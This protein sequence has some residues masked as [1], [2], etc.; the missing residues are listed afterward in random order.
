MILKDK[1]IFLN[2]GAGFMGSHLV[3]TLSKN[4]KL[5]V[6]DNF[7]AAVFSED[8]LQQFPNVTIIRGDMRE[9]EKISEAMRGSDVV[10]HLA[11]AHIRLSLSKPIEVHEVNTTGVLTT[12]KA[13]K[14]TGVKR[15][16]YLSSSEVYGSARHTFIK[17]EDPKNPTT[18]YGVSK[19]VGELYTQYFH[20][21][22]DL[23]AIIIRL[24]NTYGPRAHFEDVYGEVIPRMCIRALAGKPPIVFGSGEQ[25][26]DFTY[27]TDTINGILQASEEDNLL[28]DVVN[29]AYGEEVSI[30]VVAQAIKK[31]TGID[32]ISLPARPHDVMRH[33]ADISKAKRMLKWKPTVNIHEGIRRYM[34]WLKAT[35]PKPE[36]LLKNIPDQN[37]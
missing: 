36:K 4:N 21:H 18:V 26:R 22:E 1:H 24:F 15:F 6:Y 31:V 27:I 11:A 33:A 34:Q 13:A 7:S 37:W 3:E 16:I 32:A 9:E 5:T 30:Q 28:G 12:L 10:I 29:I 23:P 19:Y 35:Y 8:A 25:T 17:E 20:K 2:G 14:Y